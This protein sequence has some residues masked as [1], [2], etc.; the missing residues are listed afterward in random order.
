[1]T[2]AE[3]LRG[4]R[5]ALARALTLI[6]SQRG[7]HRQQ[8]RELLRQLPPQT[9]QRVGVT[10]PPGAGKST[11]IESL[12]QLAIEQGYKVGVLAIDPSSQRTGGSIL[13]DKTRME[14]LSRNPQAFVRPTPTGGALGGVARRTREAI[15]VL[16]AAGYNLILVETV[17]VGQSEVAVAHL[18]DTVL[19]V[20]LP[21]SGDDVQGIKRGLMENADVVWVNKADG[22]RVPAAR[23]TANQLSLALR[24]LGSRT[25]DWQVPVL[26]GSALEPPLALWDSL[27]QH[28]QPALLQLRGRQGAYWLERALEERLRTDFFAAPG[29]AQQWQEVNRRVAAAEITPEDGLDLLFPD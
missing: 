5:G 13:G 21:G 9:S 29:R 28:F 12:G 11:L 8:A 16:E 17:G 25:P 22:D 1:V 27:R 4:D 14:N 19:L 15:M 24:L 18:V 2:A 3:V 20:A 7:D 6:E 10:G 26:M 23:L